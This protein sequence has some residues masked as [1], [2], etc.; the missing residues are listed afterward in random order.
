MRNR[1]MPDKQAVHTEDTEGG[2]VMNTV[3]YAR[4]KGYPLKIRG[5]DGYTAYL[6]GSQ[7]LGGGDFMGI[8]RYPGGDCCHDLESIRSGRGFEIL[9]E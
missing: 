8:Y 4:S 5:N 1:K 3:E 6:I 2:R 7:P 9:E